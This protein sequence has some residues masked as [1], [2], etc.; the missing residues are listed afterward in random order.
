MLYVIQE[1]L[2]PY[3]LPQIFQEQ[4]GFMPGRGTRD[5]LLNIRQIIE[6]CY[7][8]NITAL[9]CFLDYTKAFDTVKW[10]LL[11][12]RTPNNNNKNYICQ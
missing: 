5:Q 10:N 7:E 9:C 6:K 8:Y 12:A 4:A 3:L 1:R 2:K 11:S